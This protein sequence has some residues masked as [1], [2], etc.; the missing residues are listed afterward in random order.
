[1]VSNNLAKS[2]GTLVLKRGF[3]PSLPSPFVSIRDEVLTVSP[4][5]QK[6]GIVC[7]TTPAADSSGHRISNFV[8]LNFLEELLNRYLHFLSFLDTDGTGSHCHGYW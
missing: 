4:N 1:M 3:P 2:R 7:P 6:R 5:R 8:V